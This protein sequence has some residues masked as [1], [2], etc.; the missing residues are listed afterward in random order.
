MGLWVIFALLTG[1]AVF[2]V[3]W[4]LSRSPRGSDR[5]E[6]DV[7]FYKA[8][9]VEIERDAARG[10]IGDDEAG[11]AKTE[12]ARRLM[13]AAQRD[14][15]IASVPSRRPVR[16]VSLGALAFIPVMALLLYDHVGKPGLPDM[17]LEA[18]LKAAA[19]NTA[20]DIQTAIA[21]IERHLI[22]EP[23]DGRGYEV[24]AP[25]YLRLGRPDDAARAY[26]KAIDI[27]G[28]TAE[29]LGG[30]GEAQTYVGNGVVTADAKKSFE[31]AVALDA[32]S[33]RPTYY[34]G[35][36][37][38][39]DGDKAKALE[40]WGRLVASSPP[41]APWLPTVR[42]RM[43]ELSGETQPE[44]DAKQGMQP[45]LAGKA[46]MAAAVQAL[47]GDQQ[48]AMIHRMVDGLAGRLKD[49]GGDLDGWLRLMRAYRVLNEQDKAKGALADAKRNFAADAAATKRIDD[50]AHELGLEG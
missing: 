31:Q 48:Q 45:S 38:Q 34:L 11:I 26:S 28:P 6:L 13:A 33:P 40:I 2:S 36:A 42:T 23:G 49:N 17:P 41:D 5:R 19:P 9:T 7:A 16:L 20:M 12:A 3:L 44:A 10:L 21:K 39:Q 22:E 27:L 4:P 8:Q 18:R 50:L 32:N 15:G 35:L 25:T 43:A 37:A 1:V 46:D 30:L 24:I 14:G 29:R 47:P